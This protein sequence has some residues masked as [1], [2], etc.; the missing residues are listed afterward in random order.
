M[1]SVDG[2]SGG[3]LWIRE[4][5]ILNLLK[6]LSAFFIVVV[7]SLSGCIFYKPST[8]EKHGI[9]TKEKYEDACNIAAEWKNDSIFIAAN[10]VSGGSIPIC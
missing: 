8:N 4:Q 3:I 9:T 2:R 1:S 5:H 7:L 6:I 10:R